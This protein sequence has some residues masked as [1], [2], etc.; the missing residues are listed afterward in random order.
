[1]GNPCFPVTKSLPGA[2]RSSRNDRF[3]LAPPDY[4][5]RAMINRQK[6]HAPFRK[7]SFRYAARKIYLPEYGAGS[8]QKLQTALSPSLAE[9]ASTQWDRQAPPV[10]KL[11][12]IHISEPTRLDVIAQASQSARP[13]SG[14]DRLRLSIS[15]P[16]FVSLQREWQSA[17]PLICPLCCVRHSRMLHGFGKIPAVCL[18]LFQECNQLWNIL[19]RDSPA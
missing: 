4:L 10:Y 1:M 9:R 3:P 11:S 19:L 16:F 6:H 17:V 7:L 15:A 13:R 14:I 8:W 12:L 5:D 18:L 2:V